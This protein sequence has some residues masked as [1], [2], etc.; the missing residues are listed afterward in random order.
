[1]SEGFKRE[2]VALRNTA[3]DLL[4]KDNVGA[5]VVG[6]ARNRIR[7]SLLVVL[8][9]V[10]GVTVGDGFSDTFL[11]FVSTA[12]TILVGLFITALIFSFDKFY[13]EPVGELDSEQKIWDTKSY[14]YSK[15]FAF[16]TGYTIVLSIF[17]L[18][19]LTLNAAYSGLFK[20]NVMQLQLRVD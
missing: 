9:I 3:N 16:I 20:V 11:T 2:L 17:A 14:N 7:R 10:V 18:I 8:C 13:K 15:R 6:K 1:M 4:L 19:L 5:N 12:L